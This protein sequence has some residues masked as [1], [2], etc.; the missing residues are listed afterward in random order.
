MYDTIAA[1]T[2]WY[3]FVRNL[4]TYIASINYAEHILIYCYVGMISSVGR[5]LKLKLGP[6]CRGERRGGENVSWIAGRTGES[7]NHGPKTGSVDMYINR[8]AAAGFGANGRGGV[9]GFSLCSGHAN[10]D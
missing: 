8:I 3:R 1:R 6:L 4:L 9:V 2:Y 7:L 5:Y 10:V